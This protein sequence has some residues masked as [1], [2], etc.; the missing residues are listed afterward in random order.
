MAL[1]TST[2]SL[3]TKHNV[4]KLWKTAQNAYMH[5][6]LH[7][8]MQVALSLFPLSPSALSHLTDKERGKRRALNCTLLAW[9]LSGLHTEPNVSSTVT[10]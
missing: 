3:Y 8:E 10:I 4:A 5:L 9:R 7:I 2:Y 1:G 6:F